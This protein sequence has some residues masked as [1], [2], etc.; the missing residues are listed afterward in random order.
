MPKK[1]ETEEVKTKPT[2]VSVYNDN[3]Q[4]VRAYSEEAHGEDFEQL[5]A[6]FARKKGFTLR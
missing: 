1:K 5:A 4:L 6:E 3:G 2:S